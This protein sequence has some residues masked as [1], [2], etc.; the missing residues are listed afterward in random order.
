MRY[1][2]SLKILTI[3]LIL[4]L[5]QIAL[6]GLL[7]NESNASLAKEAENRLE[8]QEQQVEIQAGDYKNLIDAIHTFQGNNI[9]TNFEV[10]KTQFEKQCGVTVEKST[11]NDTEC[12]VCG[13]TGAYIEDTY[14]DND[15]VADTKNIVGGHSS[16]F[17]DLGDGSARKIS[18]TETSGMYVYGYLME[19]SMYDTTILNGEEYSSYSKI[20]GVYKTKKCFPIKNAADIV[21]GT[22]CVGINEMGTVEG[23]KTNMKEYSFG[24]DGVVYLINTYENEGEGLDYTGQILAHPAIDEGTDLS[25]ETYIAEMLVNKEGTIT[26]TYNGEEKVA[27]YTYY[28]PYE[29]IVVAEHSIL[30]KQAI[31][32]DVI[33]YS[34][35]GLLVVSVIIALAFS[36]TLTKPIKK[37]KNV[38]DKVTDGDF[39]QKLPQSK[40]QDEI[41]DLTAS[42]EMLIMALKMKLGKK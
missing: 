24:T 16:I 7:L 31:Q 39:D 19:G 6:I 42:I 14:F 37:L 21:V 20:G 15:I 32:S 2:I 11:Y 41:S 13:E 30:E 23:I 4:A 12:L 17:V 1:S 3:V 9:N 33:I 36:R 29:M 28:E 22:M 25:A 18:T 27:A 8:T 26:Y 10:A 38:A 40:I 5:S 35:I 34:S